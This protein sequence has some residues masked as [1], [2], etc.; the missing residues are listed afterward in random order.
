MMA[1]ASADRAIAHP[2]QINSYG[3]THSTRLRFI[4]NAGVA[5]TAITFENLLDLILVGTG[6]TSVSDLFQQVKVRAVEM[7]A[8][9]VV[10]GATSVQV[11]FRDQTAGFV[12]DAKI[13]TDTSMGIQ[14]AHVRARPAVRSQSSLF[15]FSQ[16]ASAFTVTCPSGTVIDVELTF[17]GLPNLSVNAQNASVAT[18]TG[19]WYYRGLD[20]LAK[21]TTVFVPVIDAASYV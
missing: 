11:E 2:P 9:P 3:I 6:V 12:G 17:R 16:A 1:S 19:A 4:T 21:A 10:G 15:Q 8:V 20:G 14:P 7:W 18:T 13:H 5:Q